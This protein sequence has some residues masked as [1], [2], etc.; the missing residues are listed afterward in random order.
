M[1]EAIT[2]SITGGRVGTS[3]QPVP[4]RRPAGVLPDD[5][6]A[7]ISVEVA[8]A[9]RKKVLDVGTI[10]V[11]G[12]AGYEGGKV[13]TQMEAFARTKKA[14]YSGWYEDFSPFITNLSG[15]VTTSS[16]AVLGQI[17]NWAASAMRDR[18]VQSWEPA[19]WAVTAQR[20]IAAGMAKVVGWVACHARRAEDLDIVRPRWAPC[21]WRR[22]VRRSRAA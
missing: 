18:A 10:N 8:G 16:R 19:L 3:M 11:V 22:G 15:G 20:K 6:R 21:P 17:S 7:D 5:R 13:A 14:T 1:A 2:S 9:L 4:D 12:K